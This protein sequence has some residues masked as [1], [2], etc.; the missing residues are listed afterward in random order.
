MARYEVR[1]ARD[2]ATLSDHRTRQGAIDAWR[3]RHAG[4]AVRVV[5]TMSTGVERV[6]VEGTWY[7]EDT[8]DNAL[9]H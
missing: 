9:A 2:G 1:S 5:R 3:E 7:G 4:V 8:A 6:V